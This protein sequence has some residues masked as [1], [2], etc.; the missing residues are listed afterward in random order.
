MEHLRSRAT[1]PDSL[2]CLPL[3]SGSFLLEPSTNDVFLCLLLSFVPPIDWREGGSARIDLEKGGK[4]G[5]FTRATQSTLQ[6][7]RR[8]ATQERVVAA[9]ASEEE[10]KKRNENC[11]AKEG[12]QN[13]SG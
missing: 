7:D 10:E 11:N 9:A 8:V 12:A 4:G 6:K 3:L 2:I 1:A 13:E 5:N